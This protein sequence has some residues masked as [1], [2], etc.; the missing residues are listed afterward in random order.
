MNHKIF[1]RFFVE[2]REKRFVLRFVRIIGLVHEKIEST[3][4]LSFMV[5]DRQDYCFRQSLT[6]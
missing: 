1:C 4:N 5:S 6:R 2:N 3:C